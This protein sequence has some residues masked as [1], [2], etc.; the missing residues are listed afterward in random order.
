MEFSARRD[1]HRHHAYCRN[2]K[3][4]VDFTGSLL[5]SCMDTGSSVGESRI[6]AESNH[7]HGIAGVDFGPHVAIYQPSP[8]QRMAAE[9]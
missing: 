8:S 4:N 3:R 5:G 9:S 1:F 2:A 6:V 7:I